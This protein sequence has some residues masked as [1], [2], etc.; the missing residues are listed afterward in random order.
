M[1][2]PAL[3]QSEIVAPKVRAERWTLA[4]LVAAALLIGLLSAPDA[5]RSDEVW[6]LHA[7]SGSHAAMIATLR[8]DIH[9]PLFYE[10]LFVWTR[11]FGTSEIA[12]HGLSVLL[13]A[14][15]VCALY[16][17]MR[18]FAGVHVATI[19][20]AV[21]LSSPLGILGAQ[22]ARMYA[23]LSLFSILST[24][25]YWT[26]FVEGRASR[27]NL[28]WLAVV[29]ALGTFT[30]I[31]FFFLLFAE[32][33]HWLFRVR[34]E[35]VRFLAA[36]AASLAPYSILWL[37]ALIRQMGKSQEAL[38]W[39]TKP[40]A[41]EIVNTLFVYTGTVLLF[42]P[43]LLWMIFRQRAR[44]EAWTGG[45]AFLLAAALLVPLALSFVKPVFY[46]RF[47]IVGLHLFAIAFAGSVA[48]VSNWQVPVMLCALAAGGSI[49]GV[50][51]PGKC[52]G[53]WTAQ[54][55]AREASNGDV[56]IFTAL[57]RP[58]VDHYL[59]QIPHAPR[60]AETSF[61]AEIDAHPGYEGNVLDPARL[62]AMESEADALIARFR[63]TGVKILFFHG[64]R[65]ETESILR[66]RL[67]RAFRPVL[68]KS[69][70]CGGM[71]CYYNRVAIY[72]TL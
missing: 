53:R 33:L 9:P 62:K 66:T 34:R 15:G 48:R 12:V 16:L 72:A 40:G 17:W 24:C 30:H 22:L 21:Y 67:E 29:N 10:L 11:V 44:P 50:A 35:P 45:F 32:C 42:T 1:L 70:D 27:R 65:E 68:E 31:W 5:F 54:F 69:V 47:T 28:V 59:Q 7:V 14:A 23:L 25:L 36:L 43:L 19:A 41:D 13:M 6:S 20:A 56:A 71:P 39:V 55:L 8:A 37:P 61:P 64:F 57:S 51:F 38:A 4:G 26:V 46:P 58:P 3:T 49:Y 60:L 18:R 52:D 2:A 63:G